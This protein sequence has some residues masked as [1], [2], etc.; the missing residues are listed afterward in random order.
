MFSTNYE[1]L[2][3]CH[4]CSKIF[5]LFRPC[6]ASAIVTWNC[7]RLGYTSTAWQ[8]S[9]NHILLTPCGTLHIT[10]MLIT[11]FPLLQLT[12]VSRYTSANCIFAV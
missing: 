7:V 10:I 5:K 6:M 12:D 4:Y 8:V 11:Y 2:K 9:D 3:R 1:F